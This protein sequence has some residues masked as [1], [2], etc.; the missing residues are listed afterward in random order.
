MTPPF[1]LYIYY[2]VGMIV[3]T[4]FSGLGFSAFA[5][6]DSKLSLELVWGQTALAA[7]FYIIITSCTEYGLIYLIQQMIRSR[8]IFHGMQPTQLG[9]KLID[10]EHTVA[11]EVGSKRTVHTA[12]RSHA[13]ATIGSHGGFHTRKA[14]LR[15]HRKEASGR[16]ERSIRKLKVLILTLPILSIVAICGLLLKMFGE[17][18]NAESIETSMDDMST[19]YNLLFDIHLYVRILEVVFLQYYAY[20]KPPGLY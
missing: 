20:T 2:T 10:N 3:V 13:H 9:L 1:L 17:F 8:D 14:A 18:K 15:R 6:S 12:N 16:T 7:L 4:G 19:E 5:F 11:V